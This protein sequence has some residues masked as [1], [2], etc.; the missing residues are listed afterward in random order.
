MGQIL[1][2]AFRANRPRPLGRKSTAGRLGLEWL[3]PRRMLAAGGGEFALPPPKNVILMIGDGMG[4]EHVDAGRMF[5]GGEI[6]FDQFPYRAEVTTYSANSSITDSA[7]AGTA[8]ATGQKV[9]NGV[10]STALPGDG[11]ELTTSLETFQTLGKATG[12]V[13]TT[14]VTHATPAAFGAHANSRTDTDE[15][16]GDLLSQTHPNVLFGG[17]GAGMTVED[18]MAAGYTVIE[19]RD[20]LLALDTGTETFVSGQFGSSHL[21]YE[22]DGLGNLPHLSE[23]TATALDVLDNDPDGFFMM[24]EGGR[25]DHAGHGNDIERNVRETVEFANTVELVLDWAAGRSDTL[26][27]VTADHETG[28]L[29]VTTDNGPGVAPEVTWSTTGHTGVNVPIYAWGADAQLFTGVLDDT[30]IFT[31]IAEAVKPLGKVDFLELGNLD[32]SSGDLWYRAETTRQGLFTLEATSSEAPGDVTL[33]L[34]DR[35]Y[36]EL[37]PSTPAGGR[38]RIDWQTEADTA[39]FVRLSGTRGD[40]ELRLANLVDIGPDGTQVT[41]YGTDGDDRFEVLA[42]SSLTVVINGLQYKPPSATHVQF[43]GGGG[44]DSA[45]VIATAGIESATLQPHSA[46]VTGP[47]YEVQLTDVDTIALEGDGDGTVWLSDSPGRDKFV[48][49]AGFGLLYGDG[50]SNQVRAVRNVYAEASAGGVDTAKL[51]DSPDDDTLIAAPESV[52]L[53]S[54]EFSI[55]VQHFDG[56]HAYATAGGDDRASFSDSPGDDLYVASPPYA[57]LFGDGFYNRAKFFEQ[58]VAEATAGGVDVTRFYDSPGN[59]YFV[60]TPTYASLYN[61]AY[62]DQYT[63]GFNHR[64]QGFDGVH[65]YATAGGIDQA[66][67]Y[68]SPDADVFYADP[69]Q[70]ALYRP[71]EYYNRAKYFESVHAFA[72]AGGHDLARLFGSPGD[73]LFYADPNHGALYQ[74]GRFYNRAKFFEEVY[75]EAGAGGQDEADLHDSEFVDLLEA[76]GNVAR[77]SNA[78]LDFLYEVSAFGYVKATGTTEGDRLIAPTLGSL[79]FELDPVGTWQRP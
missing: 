48:G 10:I 41:V 17:G 59:D 1:K 33:T 7:A 40:I 4:P 37:A 64:A 3:E 27:L 43:S 9:N 18:A 31:L 70:G 29:T 22:Y 47:N 61:K 51:Y 50:F 2:G 12:L 24:V 28:G 11:S 79:A 78:A 71:G 19:D 57:A 46:T 75:A 35:G 56:V 6:V 73:D 62:R 15:I 8:M 65:A 25:I 20:G 45:T 5:L 42:G 53:F 49:A 58:T 76:D 52:R 77:L 21:P 74:P 38:P 55:E 34:Y 69:I 54:E 36:N 32:P 67:L 60:A 23:M 26:I 63:T 13:T 39:Y 72:T 30:D 66:R 16:A 68:D 14:T 44:L